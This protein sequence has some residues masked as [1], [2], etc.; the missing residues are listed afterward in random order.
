M[1]P[2]SIFRRPRPGRRAR[3]WSL[4]LRFEARG[5]RGHL[6]VWPVTRDLLSTRAIWRRPAAVRKLPIIFFTVG[7]SAV[8][9]APV[10]RSSFGLI[11]AVE[12]TIGD[13]ASAT[14]P[15]TRA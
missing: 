1:V 6:H 4:P 10:Q 2:H 3:R 7:K 12:V 8:E 9:G 14:S 11:A 15:V 5:E 13:D